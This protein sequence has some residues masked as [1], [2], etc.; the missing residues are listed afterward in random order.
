MAY[1]YSLVMPSVANLLGMFA[2]QSTP[3]FAWESSALA[4][5]TGEHISIQHTSQQEELK[6]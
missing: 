1:Q 5:R 3:P 6:S 4:L 2:L